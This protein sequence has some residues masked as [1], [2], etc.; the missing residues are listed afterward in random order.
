V[1]Y[2]QLELR[3]RTGLVL[4]K[5]ADVDSV[6]DTLRVVVTDQNAPTELRYSAFTAMYPGGVPPESAELL[7]ELGS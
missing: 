3:M 7:R 4:R 1:E 2:T 6:F 5:L